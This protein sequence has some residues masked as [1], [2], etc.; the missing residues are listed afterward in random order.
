MSVYTKILTPSF[1][2]F[3]VLPPFVVYGPERKDMHQ[4]IGELARY[5]EML[6]SIEGIPALQL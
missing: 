6:G 2:G 4:R 5:S 3:T 1:T